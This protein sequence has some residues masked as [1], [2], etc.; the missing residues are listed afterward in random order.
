MQPSD[1][2]IVSM[3]IQDLFTVGCKW[4]DRSQRLLQYYVNCE[5]NETMK[6]PN[7]V[8]KLQVCVNICIK[9]NLKG[10]SSF[11]IF[12]HAYIYTVNNTSNSYILKGLTLI[13][14]PNVIATSKAMSDLA[15]D[16]TVNIFFRQGSA[17]KLTL[18]TTISIL[19]IQPCLISATRFSRSKS[20]I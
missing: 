16:A 12:L 18:L 15:C 5:N 3:L 4:H 7:T 6:S 14:F 9:L 2:T 20:L 17:E 1:I 10:L 8:L 11:L 19:S 13:P